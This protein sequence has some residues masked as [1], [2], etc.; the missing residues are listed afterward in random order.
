MPKLQVTL[1]PFLFHNILQGE[2][3]IKNFSSILLALI[4]FA[5]VVFF[6]NCSKDSFRVRAP[7]NIDLKTSESENSLQLPSSDDVKPPDIVSDFANSN[8]SDTGRIY[9]V[10]KNGSDSSGNGSFTK[11]W[12]TIAL[13]VSKMRAGDTTYVRSGLYEE[14]G[15]RFNITGTNAAP[16]KLLNY[17]NEFP[18]LKGDRSNNSGFEIAK[19][20][21]FIT[22][23]GFEITSHKT[24]IDF[25]YHAHD[26]VIRRNWIHHNS[27]I[28]N[29]PEPYPHSGKRHSNGILGVGARIIIDRNRINNNGNFHECN[30]NP[31]HCNQDHAMYIHGTNFV[32][33]NNLIYG[34]LSYG[35]QVAASY[36]DS[37]PDYDR[38][39]NWVIANNTIAYQ[40]HRS[41]IVFWGTVTN[42]KVE[43]NILY[44]NASSSNVWQGIH[45]SYSSG[46][47]GVVIRNNLSYS[48]D[49]GER[50]FISTTGDVSE[51]VQYKQSGNIVNTQSPLFVNAPSALPASP[52]FSLTANSPAINKGMF[53][54]E[55]Q[56]DFLGRIRNRDAY[57]L[58]AIEF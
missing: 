7:N 56:I 27:P 39:K 22:I 42:M 54:A 10:A 17:P 32:I 9:Y 28:P 18:V 37:N 38:A 52:N 47:T 12:Q 36:R 2:K 33:T 15:V 4:T 30:Q 5:L 34:N 46:S 8:F 40:K 25:D 50:P 45:F 3:M 43:N 6:Q 58:G 48:S 51:G 23:E 19:D 11:P 57:D 31:A 44:E 41:A 26:I 21:G 1:I 49:S 53:S 55:A 29:A 14:T 24:G 20:M 16:I 35:V 13:A